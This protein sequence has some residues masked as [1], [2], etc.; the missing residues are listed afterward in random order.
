MGS[1]WRFA[2]DVPMLVDMK[3]DY[4][5]SRIPDGSM[6]VGMRAVNVIG[7]VWLFLADGGR[8]VVVHFEMSPQVRQTLN[9]VF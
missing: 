4:K 1:K 5:L 7:E 3:V 8:S 9:Y 6:H 2:W